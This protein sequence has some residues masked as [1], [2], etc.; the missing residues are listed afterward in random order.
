MRHSGIGI[1]VR[2]RR[3]LLLCLGIA[4]LLTTLVMLGAEL[5][6]E[7]SR[8][9]HEI[10]T[11]S[12]LVIENGA[13]TIRFEDV[14][15]ATQLLQSLRHLDSVARVALLRADW[16]PFAVFPEAGEGAG[17]DSRSD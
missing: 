10:L 8:V 9:E 2:L 5:R 3:I 4:L 12:E 16:A 6:E 15:T 13:A 11:L 7:T 14:A 1:A 17:D